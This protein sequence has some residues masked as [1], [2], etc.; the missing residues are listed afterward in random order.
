MEL[1]T[2][3]NLFYS[4]KRNA[5]YNDTEQFYISF[6]LYKEMEPWTKK[7]SVYGSAGNFTCVLCKVPTYCHTEQHL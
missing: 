4:D 1:I 2:Y 7:N 5:K 3:T 6:Q